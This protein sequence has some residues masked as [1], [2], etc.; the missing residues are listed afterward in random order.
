MPAAEVAGSA[1]PAAVEAA[2]ESS[3][4]GER[5]WARPDARRLVARICA[6]VPSLAFAV[7]GAVL[8]AYQ[9]A[10]AAVETRYLT[11][12]GVCVLAGA[13]LLAGAVSR[14][15]AIAA[16]MAMLALWAMPAGPPRGVAFGVVLV[17]AFVLAGWRR[18]RMRRLDVAA[19]VGGALAL[20]ALLRAGEL[21]PAVLAASS[22]AALARLVVPPVLAG[23][24]L[25]WLS[26]SHGTGVVL[27]AGTAA[28]L[29]AQGFTVTGALPLLAFAAVEATRASRARRAT[30]ELRTANPADR[31]LRDF[32]D[33]ARDTNRRPPTV[34]DDDS[35]SRRLSDAVR[36]LDAVAAVG[37]GLAIAALGVARPAAAAL[38]LAAAALAWLPRVWVW[39]V[40]VAPLVYGLATHAD[41]QRL[42]SLLAL[43]A[44]VPFA[45][46]PRTTPPL[47]LAGAVLVGAAGAL[48]LPTPAGLAAAAAA[49]ALAMREA[50]TQ[51]SLQ[52]GWLGTLVALAALAASY[53]WLRSPALEAAFVA[54]VSPAGSGRQDAL[55]SA[56]MLVVA[57]TLLSAVASRVSVRVSVGA[58]ALAAGTAVL[59]AMPGP[60]R[61]AAPANGA[62]LSGDLREWN[63][64]L[65]DGSISRVRIVSS[66]ADAAA[67]SAGTAV[68][69]LSLERDGRPL[70]A[71]TL[72]A[73][74]DTAEW[75]ADRPDLRGVATAGPIWWSSLPPAGN[76]FAHAY[77]STWR[78]LRPVEA[79]GIRI[80]RDPSLPHEVTLSL[81]RVEVSE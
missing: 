79:N 70:A 76:F 39:L 67:L 43:V 55:L 53:P 29:A 1:R 22:A 64:P 17:A 13:A 33:S 31:G 27:G 35:G 62:A 36:D 73:G 57:A 4:A 52:R 45:F 26:R 20:H 54:L 7:A 10:D 37:F 77:A 59:I 40:A 24:A 16:V 28:A 81:L 42:V 69:T 78:L 47:R 5:G 56:A 19:A 58:L 63:A 25:A 60:A 15:Q 32:T 75:A 50:D 65:R 74:K 41:P 46:M 18:L 23:L 51:S 8:A 21:L 6:V 44:L 2:A 48:L 30:A 3:P 34:H 38:A 66:L 14:V 49:L 71:W 68:A 80:V 11:L 72:R 61:N 12:V 9:P